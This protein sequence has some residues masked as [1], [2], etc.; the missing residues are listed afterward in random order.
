[1]TAL[2]AAVVLSGCATVGGK[3]VH[4]S[5]STLIPGAD[6]TAKFEMTQNGNTSIDLVVQHLAEPGKLTPPAAVYVVWV[7][8][9][10][11]STLQNVGALLLD[12]D[13]AGELHTVTPL[14]RFDLIV[15]AETMPQV[16]NPTGQPLLWTSY[17][18]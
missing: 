16:Q 17:N 4:L 3:P 10:A 5:A 9:P 18:R 13:L 8:I 7:K 15:T 14:E 6:G 12:K 11:E 2:M 1:M